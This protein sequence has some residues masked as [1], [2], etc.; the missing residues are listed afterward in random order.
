L[1]TLRDLSG[2]ESFVV[3]VN[4]TTYTSESFVGGTSAGQGFWQNMRNGGDAGIR[5]FSTY[6]RQQLEPPSSTA[7]MGPE[8]IS[9]VKSSKST[10]SELYELIRTSLRCATL[11]TVHSLHP[12][13][14]E[15]NISG[16]RNAE[17]KWTQ[18]SRLDIY[19]V[20]LVGWPEDIPTQNPST[21]K[22]HQNKRLLD[23]F[24]SGTLKFVRTLQLPQSAQVEQD[25]PPPPIATTDTFSW[26]VHDQ[27][28]EAE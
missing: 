5:A 23:L 1:E 4:P 13:Q 10:K 11:F 2:L 9:P 16:I 18:H 14:S 19:G 26:A 8:A 25:T 22:A 12:D 7:D 3:A 27:Y 20:C 6:A 17:M 24:K 21:L 15:R 28:G